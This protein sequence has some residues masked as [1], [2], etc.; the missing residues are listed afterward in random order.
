[1]AFWISIRAYRKAQGAKETKKR[2]PPARLPD[3][4]IPHLRRW[5]DN[6]ISRKF[7]VEFCGKRIGRV[8]KAFARV[9]ADAGLNP[10]EVTLARSASHRCDVD[11]A[12]WGPLCRGG[13]IS[14]HDRR[15]AGTV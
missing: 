6:G 14:R 10:K 11:D 7:A 15:D 4:L 5:R 2:Q 3:K 12:E 9:V 13:R 8:N 1:M